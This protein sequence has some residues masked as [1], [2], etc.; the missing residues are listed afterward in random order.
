MN[1]YSQNWRN[2]CCLLSISFTDAGHW[3]EHTPIVK[4][5]GLSR[6]TGENKNDLSVRP[7][8]RANEFLS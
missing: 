8:V 1:Q 3:N 2:T 5:Q 4:N 7:C 6:P